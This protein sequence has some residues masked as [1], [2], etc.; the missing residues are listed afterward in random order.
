M[1][2]LRSASIVTLG[3]VQ[4]RDPLV[5]K[6]VRMVG[7]YMPLYGERLLN[8][9]FM[10][11]ASAVVFRA[12]VRLWLAAWK[13]DPAS[14]LP[15]DDR[16]LAELAGYGGDARRWKAI[17][18][19]ALHQF[20]KCSDGRLYHPVLAEAALA[21]EKRREKD[22]NR[23]REKPE[24]DGRGAELTTAPAASPGSHLAVVPPSPEGP[25]QAEIRT[26]SAVHQQFVGSLSD[27]VSSDPQQDQAL[28]GAL[29]VE[30][31]NESKGREEKK[32]EESVPPTGGTGGEAPASPYGGVVPPAYQQRDTGKILWREGR[33]IIHEITGWEDEKEIGSALGKWRQLAGNDILLLQV[34]REAEITPPQGLLREWVPG[35]LRAR[36]DAMAESKRLLGLKGNGKSVTEKFVAEMELP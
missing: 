13:G 2:P 12:A 26:S 30:P 19:D 8:S 34:L 4:H 27:K 5:P 24:D 3:N 33:R 32:K 29:P 18:H 7:D 25:K 11:T 22:R 36:K 14:S 15:D 6:G 17:R 1:K 10:S 35:C 28:N 21:V 16:R 9:E 23:K 20:V 31:L